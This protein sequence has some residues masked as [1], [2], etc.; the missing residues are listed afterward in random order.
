MT[1]LHTTRLTVAATLALLPLLAQAAQNMQNP[2]YLVDGSA[3]VVTNASGECWRT[4]EWT[5]ALATAPCDPVIAPAVEMAQAPAP[6]PAPM[7]PAPV[8]AAPIVPMV[9]PPQKVSFSGDALF[10]FDKAVLRPESRQ[11]LDELVRKMDGTRSDTITVTGHTDRIGSAAYNQKLSQRR[12]NAVKD[13][14][15]GKNLQGERIEAQGMGETQPVTAAGDCKGNKANAKLI[16]CLQPDRRVDVEMT[17]T[18]AAAAS[19]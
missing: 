5:P 15:V 4:G 13:Y 17:G 14:L 7:P 19:Q 8:A 12:A 16:A 6:Q 10:A 3:S 18:R 1:P 2:A 11:L 9:V